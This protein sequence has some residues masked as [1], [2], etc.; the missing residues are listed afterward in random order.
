MVLIMV[1][2]VPASARGARQA[3]PRGGKLVSDFMYIIYW[4]ISREIHK[5]Y[6][7]F[8]DNLPRR[9]REHKNKKVKTTENFGQFRCFILERVVTSEQA[10]R[11]EKYWKSS[12]G[13]KK[14]KKLYSLI[15]ARSSSD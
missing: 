1:I 4:L 9:L 14:L 15:T 6:V 7:G 5:T 3:I 12:A 13:R 10:I 11:R 8:S 2:G